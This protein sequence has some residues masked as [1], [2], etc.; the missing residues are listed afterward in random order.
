MRDDPAGT[1][2]IQCVRAHDGVE[3]PPRP[4]LSSLIGNRIDGQ[5]QIVAGS[6]GL[7]PN[8]RADNGQLAS[9]PQQQHNPT[10][11]LGGCECALLFPSGN[12]EHRRRQRR[13]RVPAAAGCAEGR[14]RAS[15]KENPGFQMHTV[16]IGLPGLL[17]Q[18]HAEFV[19]TPPHPEKL[20]I[21]KLK[22]GEYRLYS[23]KKNPKTGK[24]RNLGTFKTRAAAQKHEKAV[25]FFKRQ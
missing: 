25:Q 4:R 7:P 2:R 13:R 12:R 21:R 15:D 20:M 24:R 3:H 11:K 10:R 1:N 9:I 14:Y 16:R 19:D 17:R 8:L 22:S 6:R 5:H 18:S 23:R